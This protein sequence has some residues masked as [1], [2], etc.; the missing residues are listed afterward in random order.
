MIVIFSAR[1]RSDEFF[2]A[3]RTRSFDSRTA[4]DA[5]PTMSKAGI[6]LALSTSTEI[7]SPSTP[8]VA[9]PNVLAYKF[10]TSVKILFIAPL[11][12]PLNFHGNF[13]A[14]F[15]VHVVNIRLTVSGGRDFIEYRVAVY[16]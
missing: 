11:R 7:I 12:E 2:I 4:V 16:L 1:I 9:A 3:V 10:Q 13:F 14:G 5:K 15:N 6:P 8:S